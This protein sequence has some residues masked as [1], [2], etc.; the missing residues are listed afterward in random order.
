MTGVADRPS[1]VPVDGTAS[2]VFI[3][4]D[5]DTT[6]NQP[7]SGIRRGS[8]L[9]RS[10]SDDHA[11]PHNTA[12]SMTGSASAAGLTSLIRHQ[13]GL[14]E[15][16]VIDTQCCIMIIIN[17]IMMLMLITVLILPMG[18]YISYVMTSS[19]SRNAQLATQPST[20]ITFS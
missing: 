14:H 6:H 7:P 11:A 9:F 2:P 19:A 17:M 5:P 12:T 18:R 3:T 4:G 15:M 13:L 10:E 16:F 8:F 1:R 20:V